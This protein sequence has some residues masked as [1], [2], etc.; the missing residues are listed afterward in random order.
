MG[1]RILAAG[2]GRCQA[3]F[4]NT[5]ELFRMEKQEM[6]GGKVSKILTADYAVSGEV[7]LERRRRWWNS[8]DVREERS[9]VSGKLEAKAVTSLTIMRQ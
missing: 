5:S 1:G 2:G 6:R 3:V 8:V 9:K 4:G 7:V